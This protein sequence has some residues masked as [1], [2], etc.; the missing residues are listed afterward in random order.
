MLLDVSGG[1]SPGVPP[2]AFGL[3][4]ALLALV[5]LAATVGIMVLSGKIK[6]KTLFKSKSKTYASDADASD[7][8]PY[9]DFAQLPK[10][11]SLPYLQ[12]IN[13]ETPDISNYIYY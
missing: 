10:P 13:I 5:I 1:T 12:Y 2:I 7:A 11:I 6:W 9:T 4:I 8:F 3:I